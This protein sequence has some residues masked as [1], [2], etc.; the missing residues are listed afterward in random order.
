MPKIQIRPL[1]PADLPALVAIDHSYMT[2]YV[3]QMDLQTSPRQ[4]GVTFRETRLPRSVRLNYPRDPIALADTWKQHAGML[5]ADLDE[6]PVGYICLTIDP[7]LNIV[8]ATDLAVIR[9]M[10]RQGIGAGLLLAAQDWTRHHNCTQFIVEM[11][12]K[13]HPAISLVQKLG[14]EFCGYSDRYYTNRDIALFF[15]KMVH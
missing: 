11:Q 5:V 15:A 3:W 12:S 10:R 7:L 9:R 2:D 14:F 13:N 1:I 8:K 6:Q 4:I